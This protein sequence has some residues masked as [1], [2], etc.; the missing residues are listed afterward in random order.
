MHF[1]WNFISI[2]RLRRPKERKR[3]GIE[4]VFMTITC[5]LM[6]SHLEDVATYFSG[7]S[8]QKK[9]WHPGDTA[10]HRFN[11]ETALPIYQRSHRFRR[12]IFF[13]KRIATKGSLL[14]ASCSLLFYAPTSSLYAPAPN[15]MSFSEGSVRA[16]FTIQPFP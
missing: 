7:R 12:A 15:S 6:P 16:T 5:S 4:G 13:N 9:L 2:Q 11:L 3:C 8:P 14:P 1:E 10:F